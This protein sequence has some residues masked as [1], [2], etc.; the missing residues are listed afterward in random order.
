MTAADL[1]QYCQE[2]RRSDPLITGISASSNPFKDKKT[3]VLLWH[4]RRGHLHPQNHKNSTGLSEGLIS[5]TE[6]YCM[7]SVLF[8]THS[9][10]GFKAVWTCSSKWVVTTLYLCNKG[11]WSQ[12]TCSNLNYMSQQIS[13][14]AHKKRNV[15]LIYHLLSKIFSFIFWVS[16]LQQP[17]WGFQPPDSV[18]CTFSFSPCLLADVFESVNKYKT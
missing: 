15:H 9:T 10:C 4:F 8:S 5:V 18:F 12:L 3:C 17:Q 13:A 6:N 7:W 1:V 14:H 11:R 2:H 16:T